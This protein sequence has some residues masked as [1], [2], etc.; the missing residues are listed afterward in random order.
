MNI[1]LIVVT[2]EV[3][4]VVI[5]FYNAIYKFMGGGEEEAKLIFV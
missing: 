1:V 3:R 2:S 4:S 5:L